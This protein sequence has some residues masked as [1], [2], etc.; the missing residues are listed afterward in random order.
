VPVLEKADP[1]MDE[2]LLVKLASTTG[3]KYFPLADV[4]ALPEAVG[5]IREVTEVRVAEEELWDRWW[6]IVGIVGLLTAEWILRKR[7][8]LV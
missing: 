4:A 8:R 5:T 7:W 2:D 6:V 1:K 3:G